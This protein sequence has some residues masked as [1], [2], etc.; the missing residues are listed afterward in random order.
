MDFDLGHIVSSLSK[1]ALRTKRKID[2][3]NSNKKV[4]VYKLWMDYTYKTH[5][6]IPKEVIYV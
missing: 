4:K 6:T 1:L 5:E 3:E 2:N